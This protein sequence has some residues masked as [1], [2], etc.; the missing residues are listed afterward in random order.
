MKLRACGVTE[1]WPE[2]KEL[3]T[4]N[5]TSDLHQR[6]KTGTALFGAS[7]GNILNALINEYMPSTVAGNVEW[8]DK[9]R[10]ELVSADEMRSPL[11]GRLSACVSFR[12]N[13]PTV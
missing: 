12:I 5:L 1:Q 2:G 6:F 8:N 13:D 3:L 7:M 10:K 4:V 9:P 11:V